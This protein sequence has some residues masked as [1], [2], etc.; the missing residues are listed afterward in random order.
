[1]TEQERI[2][3][4]WHWFSSH[5]D[6]IWDLCTANPR[7]LAEMVDTRVESLGPFAWEVGP[8][9]NRERQFALSPCGDTLLLNESRAIIARAPKLVNWEFYPAKQRRVG[10]VPLFEL[11][12]RS[13][14]KV[15]VDAR[16]WS[17]L[18][19]RPGVLVVAAPTPFTLDDNE[20][21]DAV[22]IALDGFVGEEGRL[23]LYEELI[24]ATTLGPSAAAV[25]RPLHE[26]YDAV[27]N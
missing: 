9:L 10:W 18:F 6:E 25:A 8:G 2:K 27:A 13:G 11:E 26:L 1:M 15:R 22:E 4:F 21:I 14:E 19:K 3:E 17:W 24:V 23:T 7:A 20:R 12:R 5:D 16:A